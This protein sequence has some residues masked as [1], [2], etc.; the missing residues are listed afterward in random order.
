MN[1]PIAIA[2]K[3]FLLQNGVRIPFSKIKHS[4]IE[5]MLSNGILEMQILGRSK[6]LIFLRSSERLN[7]YLQNHFGINNLS[8]YISIQK[9]EDSL[10]SDLVAISSDSKL[11]RL[12]IYPCL[13][14]VIN[15]FMRLH[16]YFS[17]CVSIFYATITRIRDGY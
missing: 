7:D 10:R 4:T 16:Q 3:L 17:F 8:E 15:Y 12:F 6:K 2:E 13:L 11:K 5:T 9:L 1:L 14:T